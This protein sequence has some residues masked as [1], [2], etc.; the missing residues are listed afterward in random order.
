[1]VIADID[2]AQA[3]SVA[4]KA[5]SLNAGDKTIAV[6]CDVT[7]LDEVQAMFKQASTKFGQ[8][9]VLVNSAGWD[10]LMLFT[11]TTPDFWN[12][13]ININYV[14]VLN[15]CKTALD[16]M[17]EQ[18]SGAIL[19][20]SSDAGR[21]GE[22]REAVYGGVKAAINSFMKS[23]ARENGRYGIRANSV[24]PGITVPLGEGEIGAQSMWKDTASTFTPEQLQKVAKAVPL[25]KIGTPQD[26]ANTVCFLA[27]DAVAGH[28]TGQ[29]LSVSGG[30]SMVG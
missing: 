1:V 29:V 24:C 20:I 30:Y 17:I 23:I 14:G 26:T 8:I 4:E 11:D 10:K 7:N 2:L 28:I 13:V 12:K 15:C 21:Q 27:S 22:F 6:K 3:E 16:Y 18:K 25:R 5:N 19:S 9:N